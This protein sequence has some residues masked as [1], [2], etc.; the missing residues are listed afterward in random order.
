MS[1]HRLIR[2]IQPLVTALLFLLLA[3][4]AFAIGSGEKSP[5]EEAEDNDKKALSEYND[6]VKHMNK[7]KE[8]AQKGDS[9]F[10]FNYRATSDAKAR[11]EF[12]KAIEN[13]TKSI[14][15]NP[16][17]PEA[18]NNLGY[19]YRKVDK[20]AESLAAY[21]TAIR[22][23]LD[24]A[25]AREYRAETYLAMGEIDKAMAELAYLTN[26]KSPYADSLSQSIDLYKLQHV[27]SK[28]KS[29]K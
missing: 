13:F 5:K 16:N 14:G 21:D 23:K 6:G 8:A 19:C 20:L 26:L 22:L 29:E 7:A 15:L 18:H 12:E 27:E 3:V 28:M 17:M 9:A 25:Q 24:F 11:K 2:R 1:L 4:S 10:A